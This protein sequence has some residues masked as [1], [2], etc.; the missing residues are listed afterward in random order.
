MR[1][2]VLL[3]LLISLALAGCLAPAYLPSMPWPATSPPAP[4]AP[5]LAGE[6][7]WHQWEVYT[8]PLRPGARQGLALAGMTQ[9]HL[10][11]DL[12]ADLSE[13]SGQVAILYTNREGEPLDCLYLHLYPNLWDGRMTVW[14]GQVEGQPVTLRLEADD[15]LVRVPLEP[16]LQAGASVHLSLRFA[17]PI[18]A[19]EGVGNYGE[20]ALQN[21]VLA[22]AHFYPSVA[23]YDHGWRVDAPAPQGDVIYHDASLYDV[24]FTAPA[25]LKVVAAGAILEHRVNADGTATWHL[26][27]GPMRDFNLVASAHYQALSQQVGEVVVNSYFL[28][29]DHAEGHQALAWAADALRTYE[30]AFGPYPYQELDVVETATRAGGIEYPGLV[31]LADWLYRDPARRDFFESATAHEVAHQWWYNVV[32]N[33][34]LNDPWLDEA[35]AQY[36]TYLY[37]YHVYGESGGESFLD[38]LNRRW[39]RVDFAAKPIGL[40]VAAYQDREYGAIVYGRGPLFL[41]ALQDRIGAD[42]M[43]ELLRRYYAAYAWGIA[44]PSDFQALAE[45]VAGQDLDPLFAEWVYPQTP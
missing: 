21:D 2:L 36:S 27:G 33:D 10:A 35:L 3:L 45:E 24:F 17:V 18:P 9:Y 39:A 40:P 13:L 19:G 37:F 20:F 8:A 44:T 14:D 38:S 22:L 4:A 5:E 43:A 15:T 16:A 34:Q 42:K 25:G 6:W 26:A 41:I 7:P 12:A 11:L 23:V 1:H 31:A 30:E 32:G 28:P 29:D